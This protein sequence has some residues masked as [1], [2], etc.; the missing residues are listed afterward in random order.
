M[1]VGL[2]DL[3]VECKS[4]LNEWKWLRYHYDEFYR[5]VLTSSD[6]LI[7][8]WKVYLK[9]SKQSFYKKTFLTYSYEKDVF[10]P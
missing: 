4:D 9:I 7:N 6:K 10:F 8:K 2:F 1:D 5:F 3:Y